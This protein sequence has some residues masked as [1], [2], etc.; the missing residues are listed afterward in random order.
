MR[1]DF[2]L[3]SAE[4]QPVIDRCV[5]IALT[6]AAGRQPTQPPAASVSSAILTE[7]Q[8]ISLEETKDTTSLISRKKYLP[9]EERFYRHE[10]KNHSYV[11][12]SGMSRTH[13][14]SSRWHWRKLNP[15]GVW[16]KSIEGWERFDH[17][18]FWEKIVLIGSRTRPPW[19]NGLGGSRTRP[20]SKNDLGGSRTWNHILKNACMHVSSDNFPHAHSAYVLGRTSAQSS[21]SMSQIHRRMQEIWPSQILRHHFLTT[22]G[23]FSQI[24]KK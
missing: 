8:L 24:L 16:A 15:Q 20:T 11:A 7:Y 9:V 19:K 22:S 10:K 4:I 3:R 18:K 21:E 17:L 6:R 1:A 2:V 14:L 5:L 23:I 12:I 13:T